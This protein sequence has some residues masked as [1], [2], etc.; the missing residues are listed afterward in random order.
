MFRLAL[1]PDTTPR[2]VDNLPQTLIKTTAEEVH[3]IL[4]GVESLEPF[5]PLRYELVLP[6]QVGLNRTGIS[7]NRMFD[8]SLRIG[9]RLYSL[10]PHA[11]TGAV[12][13]AMVVGVRF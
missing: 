6:G 11:S 7:I 8:E 1:D 5:V 9:L 2:L 3:P 12:T 13:P 10:Y 4:A